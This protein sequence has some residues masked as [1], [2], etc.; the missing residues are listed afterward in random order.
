MTMARTATIFTIELIRIEGI[1]TLLLFKNGEPVERI[2]G[3]QPKERLA[4]TL[5]RHIG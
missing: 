5:D 3:L 2:V 1:P 4:A